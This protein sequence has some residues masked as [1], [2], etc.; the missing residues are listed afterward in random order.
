M[1]HHTPAGVVSP[2]QNTFL[3]GKGT[4]NISQSMQ[5]IPAAVSWIVAHT[6][7]AFSDLSLEPNGGTEPPPMLAPQIKSAG[8]VTRDITEDFKRATKGEQIS[9]RS[10][11]PPQEVNIVAELAPGE[12]VKDGFFTLFE[13]VG[14]LE[15]SP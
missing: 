9:S 12:L 14:A 8:V 3:A 11:L 2:E 1:A 6:L 7:L 5:L 13:S 10:V 15:V 4:S